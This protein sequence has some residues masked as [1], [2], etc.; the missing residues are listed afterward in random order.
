[1]DLGLRGRGAVVTGGSRGIGRAIALGLAREGAG[2]AICARGEEQLRQTEAELRGFEVPVCACRCDVAD[3]LALTDFLHEARARLGHVDILV[4]NAFAF[5][6]DEVGWGRSLEVDLLAAVRASRTVIPWMAEQG[7]GCILHISS[8][9]GLDAG[10]PAPYAAAK[11]A[12]ISHSKTLA[13][14][15]GVGRCGPVPG[16]GAGQLD[17]RRLPGGGWGPAQGEPLNLRSAG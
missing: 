9:S 4:N 12:L 13:V 7:G 5:D 15:G 3:P 16:V 6:D 8:G 2:V 10:S 17:H 11:A 1:M 14:A